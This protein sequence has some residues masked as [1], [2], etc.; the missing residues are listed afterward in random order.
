MTTENTNPADTARK[1][2]EAEKLLMEMARMPG[3]KDI[4]AFVVSL[5]AFR[6]AAIRAFVGLC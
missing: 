4:E 2:I 6:C 3:G 5:A 1:A